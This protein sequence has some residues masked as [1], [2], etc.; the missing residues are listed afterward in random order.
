MLVDLRRHKDRQSVRV[1][2]MDG[3]TAPQSII[4]ILCSS[5]A[6]QR[7]ESGLSTADKFAICENDVGVG[8][9]AYSRN[10]IEPFS[11]PI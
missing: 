5:P 11:R 7:R 4:S 2:P 1:T 6:S 9:T 3:L 8:V 10:L